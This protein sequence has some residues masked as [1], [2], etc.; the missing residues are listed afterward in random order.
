M[1]PLSLMLY[2]HIL[3]PVSDGT[4]LLF[5]IRKTL[6]VPGGDILGQKKKIVKFCEITTVF[7]A[8]Y[9]NIFFFLFFK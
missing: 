3:K 7:C 4:N 9:T 5:Q 6:L 1:Q 2:S 8:I